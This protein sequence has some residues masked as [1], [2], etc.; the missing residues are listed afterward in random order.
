VSG[1]KP[2][3]TQICLALADLSLQ[4]PD[5]T[6]VIQEMIETFG[7]DPNSVP[8][9]LEWLT[10]LPQEVTNMRIEILVSERGDK[11]VK[12]LISVFRTKNIEQENRFNMLPRPCRCTSKHLASQFQVISDQSLTGVFNPSSIDLN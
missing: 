11:E 1:P 2:I 8:A 4:V 6:S 10:V 9:L 3:R 12:V 7:K 5:W